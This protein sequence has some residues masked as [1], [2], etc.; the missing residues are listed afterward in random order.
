MRISAVCV[1]HGRE[2]FLWLEE[3]AR[4][5]LNQGME[6]IYLYDNSKSERDL[7]LINNLRANWD[8][9]LKGFTDGEIWDI[10]RSLSDKFPTGK[11]RLIEWSPRDKD[12]RIGHRQ[13]AAYA[14]FV[15]HNGKETDWAAFIDADEYLFSPNLVQFVRDRDAE[16]YNRIILDLVLYKSRWA[17]EGMGW[18]PSC[19]DICEHL[20]SNCLHGNKNLYKTSDVIQPAIHRHPVFRQ[21]I[22][23]WRDGRLGQHIDTI[24]FNHYQATPFKLQEY[25]IKN[26]MLVSSTFFDSPIND[27]QREALLKARAR[28]RAKVIVNSSS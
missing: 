17:W 13:E 14:H 1:F 24:W 16:G 21:K 7:V 27:V 3:W 23:E 28:A 20:H 4:H 15:R 12:G 6:S 22:K 26:K 18:I 8:E 9:R 2:N 5:H 10:I 19:M 11:V 25:Y